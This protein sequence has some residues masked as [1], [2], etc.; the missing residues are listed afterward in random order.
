V[1]SS[2]A[3]RGF[4]W[5]E[6]N[7]PKCEKHGVSL[8]DIEGIFDRP[9]AVFPDLAHSRHEER[10]V[11][12]GKNRA[13]RSI[14]LVFTLRKRNSEVFIRPISARYMHK[15]EVAHYEKEAARTQKR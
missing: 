6:A 12:I 1:T 14:L 15:K 3:A 9:V 5:D 11:A 13:G 10:F 7:R 2:L 4:E 8:V